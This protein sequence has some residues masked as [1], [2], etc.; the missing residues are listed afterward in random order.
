MTGFCPTVVLSGWIAKSPNKDLSKSARKRYRCASEPPLASKHG[1]LSRAAM[2]EPLA[3]PEHFWKPRADVREVTRAEVEQRTG[4]HSE[5]WTLL[6]GGLANA[7]VRLGERVLRIYRRNPGALAL[8]AAL[9]SR[10]CSSLR[11]PAV[12]EQGEDYLLLEYVP[13][14]PICD[15]AEHGTAV[16][17]ALA[18]IH[19][20]S[21]ERAGFLTPGFRIGQPFPGLVTS[22]IDHARTLAPTAAATLGS[23][24]TQA[25]LETLDRRAPDL[26]GVVGDPVLVHGDFKS[27]NLHWTDDDRLLVLDWEF[28]Y[29]GSHLSD[30]GQLL[31][32]APAEQF[33]R[34]FAAAYVAAGGVL[35]ENFAE[36]AALLDLVNLLGLGSS[37]SDLDPEPRVADVRER[38]SC[39]LETSRLIGAG[40]CGARSTGDQPNR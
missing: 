9:L 8:E 40:S 23:Q 26:R 4:T 15:G 33:V 17:R 11:V 30:I 10:P 32:W 6:S 19:S 37:R 5:S 13:H 34:R 36:W 16:G 25:V 39:T 24:L 29:S 2:A 35:P 20:L 7:N 27:A 18:E 22:L 12:L 31:R 1:R 14:R 38:I 3:N 28:A 21:F